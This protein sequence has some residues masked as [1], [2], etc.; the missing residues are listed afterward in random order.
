MRA[1]RHPDGRVSLDEGPEGLG[2]VTEIDPPPAPT[3]WRWNDAAEAWQ[4]IGQRQWLLSR[5]LGT[6]LTPMEVLTIFQWQPA[7]VPASPDDLTFLWARQ[8]ILTLATVDLDDPQTAAA[9]G[10]CV[11]RGLLSE[12][13][14]LRILAGLPPEIE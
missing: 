14:S 10:M 6:L 7:E 4:P 2:E 3:G 1:F 9:L 11:S 12:A 5:F 13:R 8:M